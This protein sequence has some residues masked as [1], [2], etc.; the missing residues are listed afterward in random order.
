MYKSHRVWILLILVVF[1]IGSCSSTPPV[2]IETAD[3]TFILET[4]QGVRL[5]PAISGTIELWHFWASP[6]R[7]NAVRRLIAY[8]R[9]QLPN[10]QVDDVVKPFIGLWTEDAKAVAAGSGMPDVILSDRP[11]LPKDAADGTYI[12]LQAWASRDGVTGDQFWPFTWQQTLYQ[13]DTYGIPFETDVRVLFYDKNL[14]SQAG[15]NPED[16]PKTWD[17]LWAM[18][19][20]LDKKNPDGT[21]ARIAFFPLFNISPDVWGYTNGVQWINPDQTPA[22]NDPKAV[23]TLEWVKKWVD[24]YG[25]WENIQKFQKA[26]AG[27]V[28][29]DL[30]M[31]G[32]V[33][34]VADIAGYNS[35]LQ[36]YRPNITLD[37]GQTQGHMDWGI[38]LLPYQVHP[39]SWSGG[40]AM[41]IPKG[42]KNPAAAWEFIKCAT[43]KDG[44]AAWARDTYAQPSNIAAANDP[45][46]LADPQWSFFIDA[47][48]T[49][50]GGV[51][52]VK[53]PFWGDELSKRYEAVWTGQE[54]AQ[55]ALDDAQKAV[56]DAIK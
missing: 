50:T 54:S 22:L 52:L 27:S 6:I 12:D 32:S 48:K 42:A 29:N 39:A 13:G 44:Q 41:S 36:F 14:F 17:D 15:L 2:I 35:Q 43:G 51:Y 11:K 38:S 34:M 24:R 18:A 3:P 31:S 49:S 55:Q 20:K 8:C 5:N 9:T 40:F 56:E 25:G 53:Y 37:D 30:F 10:I 33:A 45:I 47:L 26:H 46:L 19:D 7:H 28:P 1:L 21:Y 16:P 23:E 4:G